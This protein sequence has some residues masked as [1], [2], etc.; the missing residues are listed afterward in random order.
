MLRPNAS[1]TA[2]LCVA[3][4]IERHPCITVVSGVLHD[5]VEQQLDSRR[6]DHVHSGAE[7]GPRFDGPA[8][9]NSHRICERPVAQSL[10]PSTADYYNCGAAFAEP[11]RRRK[12]SS[13]IVFPARTS[14]RTNT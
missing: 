13:F 11:S 5:V 12:L 6:E 9:S 4:L 7:G 3:Q 8:P 1:S 2:P 14:P 10:T